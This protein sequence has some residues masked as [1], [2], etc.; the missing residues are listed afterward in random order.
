MG[1][2]KA[3]P[4]GPDEESDSSQE[5]N[6][7]DETFV[8]VISQ[9]LEDLREKQRSRKRKSDEKAEKAQE[10]IKSQEAVIIALSVKC[11][12]LEEQT[13]KMSDMLCRERLDFA[14]YRQSI[15]ESEKKRRI[16]N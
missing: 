1:P 9:H 6:D 3:K 7:E 5:E 10:L 2:K 14:D 12:H 11:V 16:S 15:S 4:K 13:R 8:N